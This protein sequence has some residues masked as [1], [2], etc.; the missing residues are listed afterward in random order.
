M[1]DAEV[2]GQSGTQ[3][4]RGGAAA[5]A[6]ALAAIWFLATAAPAPA[7]SASIGQLAPN[8]YTYEYIPPYYYYTYF[9]PA[10]SCSTPADYLQP[11][12]TGGTHYV[13]PANGE[14]I[15][16]WSTNA[17]QGAGQ[18]MTL[19]VFRQTAGS[20]Y[21]VV[22][23]D[24]PRA[25]VQGT[26]SSGTVNTFSGLSIPVQPGD[27]IGL[28]PN[29][30]DTVND[31]CMFPSG[32][33]SYLVSN[34]NLGD[35]SSASFSTASGDR[36]NVTAVVQLAAP[37]PGSPAQFTLSVTASGAGHGTV[38][39]SPAGIEACAA[40]CSQAFDENT[41]VTLTAH[42]DGYSTF[43]GWS[44]GGCAGS[45]TCQVAVHADTSVT[46]TFAAAGYGGEAGYD[47]YGAGYGAPA[48]GGNSTASPSPG[49]AAPRRCRKASGKKRRGKARCAKRTRR[50]AA[51]ARN[52]GLGETIL[53]TTKG[54]TLYSLSAETGG[55]FVC[56]DSG[57]LSAWHPLSVPAGVQPVG[58]VKLA[59]VRR[60][61]GSLQ[62]AYHGH[63]LYSF[64]GDTGPGQANGVGLIDVGTWGAVAVPSS[65]P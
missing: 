15:T 27:V 23:H 54:F 4:R 53:T 20:T 35:H 17:S 42:P 9:P 49:S 48:A 31:A 24:G 50:L 57:C 37:P 19:K 11:S 52:D 32:G 60:P 38:Q 36:L 3:L 16:S 13:V 56:T 43:T 14:T 25:L 59:T 2:Q 41:T 45:G 10:A 1:Q 26:S 34:S 33:D 46:A 47:G 7:A 39:S 5:A 28:Y 18:M 22:G 63:P 6:F 12:V 58:P 51:K 65:K 55:K 30:A 62:V 29:N 21:E 40:S 64:G 44:G 8:P 61:D